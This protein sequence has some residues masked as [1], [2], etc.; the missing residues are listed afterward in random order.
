VDGGTWLGGS[1]E[2]VGESSEVKRRG[3][4]EGEK[5]FHITRKRT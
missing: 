2:W 4:P 3:T 1:G 5:M